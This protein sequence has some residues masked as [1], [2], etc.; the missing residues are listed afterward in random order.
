[1]AFQDTIHHPYCFLLHFPGM[2]IENTASIW[3]SDL[4]DIVNN[5]PRLATMSRSY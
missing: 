4:S 3:N 5:G 1:M 2:R